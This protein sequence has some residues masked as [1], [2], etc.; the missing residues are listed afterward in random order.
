MARLP[1]NVE[2][3]LLP[4]AYRLATGRGGGMRSPWW[5]W[6]HL[7]GLDAPVVAL[8]W[9]D[10]W[11]RFAY[12]SPQPG[13]RL[14]LGLGVWLIYLADR[15]ADV[16]RG[17]PEDAGTT[18][19]AF[20]AARRRSLFVL[21][22]AVAACL[23]ALAPR[24]LPRGEFWRGLGLLGAVG[25]Y[26]WLVHR[27]AP[28]R[29]TRALPKEAVV[30]AMFALGTGFFTVGQ[31]SAG[32]GPLL[33]AGVLFGGVC[34]LNCALITAWER[35]LIDRRDPASLLNA[36][37]RLVN[38]GLAPACGLTVVLA[39][40]AA[41]IGNTVLPLPVALAA[42]AL[43]AL[44]R[45]RRPLSADALRCLADAVLLTPLVCGLVAGVYR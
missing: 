37:P 32:L 26:F 1:A 17:R 13:E 3:S 31:P 44:D 10:W 43:T 15:L 35:S 12:A 27:G 6:P 45:W 30:G 24:V 40:A 42:A 21:G 2:P 8:I 5:L 20:V 16:S 38:A 7:L 36:F 25:A 28:S 34:F 11:G 41:L 33:V 4:R 29:W 9:Q 19:H 14:V 18:R 22:I 39:L 23:V